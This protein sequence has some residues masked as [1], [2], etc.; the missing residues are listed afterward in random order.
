MRRP[1]GTSVSA[2]AVLPGP[3]QVARW[4]L[5]LLVATLLLVSPPGAEVPAHADTGDLIL[6]AVEDDLGPEPQ[7][8]EDPDN[9]ARSLAGYDDRDLMFTWGAS[10]LLLGLV[11]TGLVVGGTLWYLLVVRANR[12]TSSS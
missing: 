7:P 3:A 2:A 5:A 6:A 11:V 12:E 1:S 9:A 4:A 8:R 10:F